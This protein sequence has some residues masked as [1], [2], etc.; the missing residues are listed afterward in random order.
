M[1]HDVLLFCKNEKEMNEELVKLYSEKRF[2]E[3]DCSYISKLL[4]KMNFTKYQKEIV[5]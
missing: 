1:C 2:K 5:I 4:W 3:F